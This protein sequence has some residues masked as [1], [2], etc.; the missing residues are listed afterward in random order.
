VQALDILGAAAQPVEPVGPFGPA[1]PVQRPPR[2]QSRLVVLILAGIVLVLGVFAGM[3]AFNFDPAPLLTGTAR[4]PSSSGAPSSSATSSAPSSSAPAGPLQVAAV[5][6]IDPEGDDSENQDL[7]K[8]VVDGDTSTNWHS[9]RYETPTFGGIKRGLGLVLDLRTARRV[10]TVTV[11][12]PGDEGTVQL[13]ASDTADFDGS[14]LLASARIAGSGDVVLRP[15]TPAS[16]RYVVLWFTRVPRT[17][18][19][20]RIVVDE[21][22]VR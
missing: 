9:E 1:A 15:S 17:D 18:E 2:E 14:R 22:V 21:V 11:T 19:G 8:N 12:A 20:R 7:A 3:R 13:R 6:A 10:T 4:E 16:T 5:T